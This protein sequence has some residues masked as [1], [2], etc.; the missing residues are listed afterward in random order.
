MN[1]TTI[2]LPE[3]LKARVERLAAAGGGSVHAFMLAAIAEVADRVELRQNF[4][5]E[6]EQRL[7]SL[8]ETGEHLSMDDLR[9]YAGPLARGERPPKPTPR[10]MTPQELTRFRASM[11]RAG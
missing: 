6:A 3:E 4:E 11:R 7:K 2:R 5:A 1:T 10:T 8:Q 9:A